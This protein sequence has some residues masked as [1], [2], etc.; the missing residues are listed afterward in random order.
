MSLSRSKVP[1]SCDE[2]ACHQMQIQTNTAEGRL[3]LV[4]FNRAASEKLFHIHILRNRTLKM[5]TVYTAWH[6]LQIKKTFMYG[7]YSSLSTE[8]K[9]IQTLET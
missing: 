6:V 8:N 1:F 9:L 2:P 7:R 4:S 3:L 5:Y